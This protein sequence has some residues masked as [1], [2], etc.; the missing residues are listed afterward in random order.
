MHELSAV[1]ERARIEKI[2]QPTQYE[3][4]F[5]LRTRTGNKKLLMSIHPETFRFHLTERQFEN[6]PQPKNFCVLL[7][8]YLSGG[9]ITKA[10]QIG[11][12]R[13]VALT[14]ESYNAIGDL[15]TYN[16]YIELMGKYSN[17]VLVNDEGV[18]IDAF[19]KV[20]ETKS[21]QRQILPKLT[22]YL[23]EV[24]K[25]NDTFGFYLQPFLKKWLAHNEYKEE[26]LL[27][28]AQKPAGY[29]YK[30]QNGKAIYTFLAI[31]NVLEVKEKLTF[32]TLSQ[33]IDV[34][35]YEQTIAQQLKEKTAHLLHVVEQTYKRD[36]KKQQ[37]LTAEYEA[38]TGFETYQHIGNLLLAEQYMLPAHA[39][40]VELTNY[41]AEDQ[42]VLTVPLDS[43]Q[44][45]VQ[46]AQMYFKKYTKAKT[47]LEKL[48]E[49]L[50][51]NEKEIAYFETIR[52][53]LMYADLQQAAEI[54]D[55][56]VEQGYMKTKH[57]GKRKTK[58]PQYRT[59]VYG[60]ITYLVG[61]NNL[62]NDYVTFKMRRKDFTWLHVKDSPGSHVLIT[63]KAPLTAEAL[64]VGALLAAYFSKMRA[65][66][67]VAVDYTLVQH[68]HKPS[69]AKPG[70]VI[71][72][73]QKTLYVSP[74]V[75]NLQTYFTDFI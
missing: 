7:R 24:S 61:K 44:N 71:Y 29:Y 13:I 2:H 48:Q 15:V 39:E 49:Q 57:K 34:Y 45:I 10:A 37:K 75:T 6:P 31:D 27:V 21:E 55:E 70:Y 60:D 74:S 42:A 9:M 56:L 35:Y 22:Y 63:K 46:N 50:A 72:R 1:L 40:V 30:L 26:L 3:L 19:K 38:A 5:H 65:S 36:V 64:H 47:A 67:N 28:A 58:I 66:E 69:G 62:Q 52:Q 16:L 32:A 20:D 11:R 33:A 53:S 25:M 54:A 68:V 18:I 59:Y 41:Y 51:K 73:E 4:I 12:D 23:P 8:K 17:I 14:I 43:G